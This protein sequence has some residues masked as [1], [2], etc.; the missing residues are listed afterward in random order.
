MVLQ[1][2][3][4]SISGKPVLSA[5]R[6]ASSMGAKRPRC[7]S[8]KCPLRDKKVRCYTRKTDEFGRPCCT[9]LPGCLA[10]RRPRVRLLQK[11]PNAT[12]RCQ[13]PPV[14][15]AAAEWTTVEPNQQLPTTATTV[16]FQNLEGD[17]MA[18][19][20]EILKYLGRP[21]V[22]RIV[23]AGLSIAEDFSK[24]S[25]GLE[26]KLGRRTYAGVILI[27]GAAYERHD[28]GYISRATAEL[29]LDPATVTKAYCHV[30]SSLGLGL[31]K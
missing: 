26:Q 29:Q 15:N 7:L 23:A 30:L 17:M 24:P 2:R 4:R 21:A 31:A 13:T 8:S 14:K 12:L 10:P 11:T 6:A 25:P 3:N 22:L 9:A 19:A 5:T 16:N 1:V 20:S 28:P 18:M 27:A